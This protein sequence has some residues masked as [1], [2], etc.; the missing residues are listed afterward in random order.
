LVSEGK[1]LASDYD[2]LKRKMKLLKD[3]CNQ[4]PTEE[5]KLVCMKNVDEQLKG[6]TDAYIDK[7]FKFFPKIVDILKKFKECLFD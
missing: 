5:S 1:S 7:V 4:F 2:S 6:E 3:N